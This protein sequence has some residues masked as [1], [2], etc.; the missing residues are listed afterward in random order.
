MVAMK[1][2]RGACQTR[3]QSSGQ[4]RCRASSEYYRHYLWN[5]LGSG[6]AKE[7]TQVIPLSSYNRKLCVPVEEG[8]RV[9]CAHGSAP[10]PLR[11]AGVP[12]RRHRENLALSPDQATP[13][14]R[15][16]QRKCYLGLRGLLEHFV[17]IQLLA[18]FTGIIRS[19]VKYYSCFPLCVKLA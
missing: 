10:H 5:Q 19:A 3:T 16:V 8:T 18:A 9:P 6:H 15:D 14:S 12:Q 11:C 1:T 17:R 4:H 13:Y 7:V 2:D